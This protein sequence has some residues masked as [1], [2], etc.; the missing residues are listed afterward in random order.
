M[1][2]KESYTGN[3]DARCLFQHCAS[4]LPL[5]LQT[6]A[7]VFFS[8]LLVRARGAGNNNK[9]LVRPESQKSVLKKRLRRR[10]TH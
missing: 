4:L 2:L 6:S 8:E 5:H 1:A 10:D 9:S 7:P 3:Y